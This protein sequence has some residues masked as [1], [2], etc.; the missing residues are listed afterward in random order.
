MNLG[1]VLA[2]YTIWFNLLG[3]SC[4]KSHQTFGSNNNQYFQIENINRIPSILCIFIIILFS[5]MQFYY[6]IKIANY[7]GIDVFILSIFLTSIT[8]TMLNGSFQAILFDQNFLNIFSLLQQIEQMLLIK[9]KPNFKIF[10]QTYRRLICIIVSLN[11]FA[12][13][14]TIIMESTSIDFIV[15][16]ALY[17]FAACTEIQIIHILFYVELLHTIM[18]ITSNYVDEMAV[19][20]IN[21]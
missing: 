8:L 6:I 12:L 1:I 16:C 5:G 10:L 17:T 14:I 19:N 2:R 13:L 20:C 11:I 4:C 3:Q 15:N 21:T 18:T 7:S 9:I